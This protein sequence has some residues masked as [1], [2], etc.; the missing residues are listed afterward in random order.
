MPLN[1]AIKKSAASRSA[2]FAMI[3]IISATNGV[4]PK[5]CNK[6]WSYRDVRGYNSR[7]SE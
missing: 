6:A 3:K 4:K 7:E 1:Y 2:S 5:N